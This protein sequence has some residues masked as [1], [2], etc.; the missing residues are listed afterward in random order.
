M[1]F[2]RSAF[3]HTINV[4]YTQETEWNLWMG[5]HAAEVPSQSLNHI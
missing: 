3:N 5:Q 4:F 1:Q 2:N